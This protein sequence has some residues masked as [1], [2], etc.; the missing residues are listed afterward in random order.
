MSREPWPL[1]ARWSRA[2]HDVL[3]WV[4]TSRVGCPGGLAGNPASL[5][6]GLEQVQACALSGQEGVS[7]PAGSCEP[8]ASAVGGSAEPTAASAS[9]AAGVACPSSPASTAPLRRRNL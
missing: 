3:A 2:C 7:G 6:A 8:P 9:G 1:T 4:I 5:V